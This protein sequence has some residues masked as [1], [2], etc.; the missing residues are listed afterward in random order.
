[1]AAPWP[2][3][4]T[5]QIAWLGVAQPSMDWGDALGDG[6]L[7]GRRRG[8]VPAVRDREGHGVRPAARVRMRR[9]RRGAGRGRVAEVPR[10]ADDVAVR[11]GRPRAVEQA[12]QRRA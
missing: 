2:T 3:T 1:M 12:R 5:P 7:A 8:T 6:D 9:A 10:V 4:T 11:V